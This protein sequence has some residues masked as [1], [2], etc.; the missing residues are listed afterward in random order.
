MG[1]M[2]DISGGDFGPSIIMLI[3]AASLGF[4]AYLLTLKREA[5]ELKIDNLPSN[6]VTV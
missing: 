2:V 6:R 1:W 4:A 3:I 5:A